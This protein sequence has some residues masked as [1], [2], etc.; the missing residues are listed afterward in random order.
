MCLRRIPRRPLLISIKGGN[1]EDFGAWNRSYGVVESA[2]PS[3]DSTWG[4]T[5]SSLAFVDMGPESDEGGKWW[6]TPKGWVLG[7][8][9]CLKGSNYAVKKDWFALRQRILRM[10]AR[11]K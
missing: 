7:K 10:V 9:A 5:W 2:E 1:G 6:H 4:R 11:A 3:D 8:K